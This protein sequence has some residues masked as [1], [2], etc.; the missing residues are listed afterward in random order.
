MQ[1]NSAKNIFISYRKQDTPGET[2]RL[3]DAL[4]Q[5]FH[6]N[7]IFRDIERLE[8]GADF[9]EEIGKRLQA[10][11]VMLAVVGSNWLGKQG[12]KPPRIQDPNDWVRVELA[13]ALQR[14]I[15]VV[16]VLVNGA[17][18]PSLEELP[19]EL[20]PLLRR[21]AH[22]IS[23]K[24]WR[25]DTEQLI[26]FLIH[27]VGITP[28]SNESE[29]IVNRTSLTKRHTPWVY[30]IGG[31]VVATVLFI[32]ISKLGNGKPAADTNKDFGG[33]YDSNSIARSVTPN[34]KNK[35]EEL[36]VG[37]WKF[38]EV[39]SGDEA[40]IKIFK[41]KTEIPTEIETASIIVESTATYYKGGSYDGE[42]E[43][44]W[45][46]KLI[47]NE[48]KELKIRYSV[49]GKWN[50]SGN[51]LNETI[52]DASVVPANDLSRELYKNS[53]PKLSDFEMTIGSTSTSE[54]LDLNES[55]MTEKS[56]KS[57]NK[58]TWVRTS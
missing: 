25:Y 1:K 18:L 57:K 41:N 48:T 29:Q 11:D 13:A 19:P 38:S 46:Y 49:S 39:I 33:S 55:T 6:E 54:I 5:H 14:S 8:P 12:D 21:Q 43:A 16:P 30:V 17:Q 53:Q 2:G 45:Q 32:I 22:E 15:R 36:L 34:N 23:D 37:T 47:S 9:V 58:S 44:T 42:G 31:L 51:E 20:Q 56:K 50:L 26:D 52:T 35:Y 4:S 28:K 10:C 7:Q 40:L 27:K 3:A 24:R